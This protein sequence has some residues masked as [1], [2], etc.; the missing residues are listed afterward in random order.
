MAWGA[1]WGGVVLGNN[2]KLPGGGVGP[3]CI[4]VWRKM[5]LSMVAIFLGGKKHE[6]QCWGNGKAFPSGNK[7]SNYI[8]KYIATFKLV[9]VL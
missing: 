6:Q 3:H 1:G 5:A 7:F 2:E 4:A 8:L 9:I